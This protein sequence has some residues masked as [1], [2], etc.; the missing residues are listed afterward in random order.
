MDETEVLAIE[1]GILLAKELDLHQ[2]VI[3]SNSLSV[4]QSILSKD[5][6]GG[7]YHLVNGILSFLDEFSSW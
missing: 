1:A 2:I 3:E 4:V 6:S 5:F 7:F